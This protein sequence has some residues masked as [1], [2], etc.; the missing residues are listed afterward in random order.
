MYILLAHLFFLHMQAF[1]HFESTKEGNENECDNYDDGSST[2]VA[3]EDF[4]EVEVLNPVK[5]RGEGGETYTDYEVVC[6]TNI[7]AILGSSSS[8]RNNTEPPSRVRTSRVRRRYSEFAALAA[9]ISGAQQKPRGRSTSKPGGGGVSSASSSAPQLPAL[10]VAGVA[11]Y[12]E[13][14]QRGEAA[15][16]ETRRAGLERFLAA[17]VSHPLVQT[18]AAVGELQQFLGFSG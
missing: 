14:V 10:P 4:L 6:R 15:F 18:G 2:Y 11:A 8:N 5:R 12:A 13:R 17:A 3:P 16:A 7:P 1:A 9:A